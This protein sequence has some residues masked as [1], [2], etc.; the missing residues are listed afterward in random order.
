[1]TSF[2]QQFLDR[3]AVQF[4]GTR[5]YNREYY[6]DRPNGNYGVEFDVVLAYNYAEALWEERQKRYGRKANVTQKEEA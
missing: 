4:I 2:K 6:T 5:I 3:V 1:M